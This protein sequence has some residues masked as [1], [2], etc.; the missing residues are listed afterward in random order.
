MALQMPYKMGTLC[1]SAGSERATARQG[2]FQRVKVA[3][4]QSYRGA[5]QMPYKM[6]TLCKSAP[7]GLIK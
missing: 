3:E 4:G 1:T 5:L 2:V 6:G 7:G